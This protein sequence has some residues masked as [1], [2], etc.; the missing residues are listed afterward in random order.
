MVFNGT[1]VAVCSL[2]LVAANR[3]YTLVAVC[4]LLVVVTYLVAEH[5]LEGMRASVVA[6]CGLSCP[7]ACEVLIPRPGIDQWNPCPLHWLA[8]S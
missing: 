8:D 7:A 1:L 2:S 5:E 3:G 4:W 6:V